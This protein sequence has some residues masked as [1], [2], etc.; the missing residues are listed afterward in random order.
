MPEGKLSDEK[1]G[2]FLVS[3]D[4][5]ERAGLDERSARPSPSAAL[6]SADCSADR[7]AEAPRRPDGLSQADPAVP[8]R[9]GRIV[10][11]SVGVGP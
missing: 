1:L 3:S 6:E 8:T 9:R 2:R 5:S 7:T 11:R 10:R 4:L